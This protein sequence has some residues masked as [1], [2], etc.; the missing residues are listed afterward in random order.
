MLELLNRKPFDLSP[1]IG[2]RLTAQCFRAR[3]D[4]DF[5]YFPLGS[6]KL[7]HRI[8][9]ETRDRIMQ[10]ARATD[11]RILAL[12]A[13]L[14]GLMVLGEA[15]LARI[16]P[17]SRHL[18]LTVGPLWFAFFVA[19]AA[20][21]PAVAIF[22]RNGRRSRAGIL[23]GA[24][25][26]RLSEGEYRELTARRWRGVPRNQKVFNLLLIVV[27]TSLVLH[28][29]YVGF[30]APAAHPPWW[31]IAFAI[32]GI[33]LAAAL[34]QLAIEAFRAQIYSRSLRDKT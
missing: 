11:R 1:L 7:G 19:A 12:M 27:M 24:P 14:F 26:V 20:T 13:I 18:F 3:D 25:V 21:I 31:G 6:R 2:T 28:E 22:G 23:E 17:P 16:Y 32:L 5:D 9:L 15:V 33:F 8:D 34:V 10:M 29:A 30:M 4:G